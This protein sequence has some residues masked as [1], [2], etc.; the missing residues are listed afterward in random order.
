M[1]IFISYAHVDEYRVRELVE[2]LRASGHDPWFDQGLTVGRAWEAQLLEQIRT[3]DRFLYALTPESVKSPWCQWEFAQAVHA[4]KPVLPV[5]IQART[6]LDD[7]F[8]G[9]LGRMQYAD[10]S[11]GP[12]GLVVAKLLGGVQQAETLDPADVPLIP[13]PHAKP[14]R[15]VEQK[16][17]GN[18]LAARFLEDAYAAF[19]ARDWDEA[20]D[21]LH[22]CLLIDPEHS[23]AQKLLVVVE[24]RLERHK[25]VPPVTVSDPEPEP[26]PA[27]RTQRIVRASDILPPPFEWIDIPAGRVELEDGHGWFDVTAF[28]IAKYPITNAQ[29]QVF[30]DADD[31]YR[32]PGWWTYSNDARQGRAENAEPVDTAFP[33]DDLPRT[34]VSWYDAIAFCR[35]LSARTG[36]TI[37]LPTDQQWQRAAQGDDGRTYPWGNEE[38][39]KR[40]C[41]FSRNVGQTTPVTEYPAGASPYGVM[42]MAGNVWDWCLSKYDHPRQAGLDGNAR[43]VVRGGSWGDDRNAARCAFRYWYGPLNRNYRFGFRVVRIS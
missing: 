39:N 21:L 27:P 9:V 32:D 40:L 8:G 23:E 22:V 2:I 6:S 11:Q 4:G 37:T 41:N 28:A 43:R 1:K 18:P 29:F 19:R 35:W 10:F 25:P 7:I 38:P 30:V 17:S 31:G 42:D 16:D 12:V 14:E 26:K 13:A 36:E 15:P 5:M 33:G 20:H 34:N 24:R 3:S